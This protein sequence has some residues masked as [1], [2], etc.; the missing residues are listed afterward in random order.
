MATKGKVKDIIKMLDAD[1]WV[2]LKK[3]GSHRKFAH[4]TKPGHVIVAGHPNEEMRPKT[5]DSILRQAGLK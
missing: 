5:W 3:T 1:G 4:P 2:Y